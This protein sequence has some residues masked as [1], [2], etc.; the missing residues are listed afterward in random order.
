MALQPRVPSAANNNKVQFVFKGPRSTWSEVHFHRNTDPA[1]ILATLRDAIPLSVKR[2]ALLSG[3]CQL[4]RTEVTCPGAPRNTARDSSQAAVVSGFAFEDDAP[5]KLRILMVGGTTARASLYIGGVIDAA[6]RR[7]VYQKVDVPL[8]D[9][10]LQ[11]YLNSLKNTVWGFMANESDS[12]GAP[13]VRII[14]ISNTALALNTITVWTA[15]PHGLV[16]APVVIARIGL[17]N[18]ATVNMP[19]N[20]LWSVNIIDATHFTLNGF[21]NQTSQFSLV[22]SGFTQMQ[23]KI[24]TQYTSWNVKPPDTR[25]VGNRTATPPARKKLKRTLGY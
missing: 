8:W 23:L 17:V 20:Q 10:T 13:R 22:N 4:L 9:S 6:I 2:A 21:P 12:T 5:N 16:A 7:D 24:F 19:V 14:S 18:G 1:G 15:R 11:T 25:K 3:G